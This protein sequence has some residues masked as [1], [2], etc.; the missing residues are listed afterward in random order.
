MN[1][2][3]R[4]TVRDVNDNAPYFTNFSTGAP[5]TQIDYNVIEN[6]H[7]MDTLGL[8]VNDDDTGISGYVFNVTS[9]PSIEDK[10][11]YSYG[12][13]L[14]LLVFQLN[15]TFDREET[16]NITISITVSN[17]DAPHLNSTAFV[18]IYVGDVNDNAPSFTHDLFTTYASEGSPTAKDVL[19]LAASDRDAGNN[20]RLTYNITSVDNP[21][22]KKWFNIS[23]STGAI[24]VVSNDIDY[25]AVGGEVVL[26]V[27]V[28]DNGEEEQLSTSTIVAVKI[29]PAI[30]FSARSHQAF[31]NYNL[32]GP[33]SYP[34]YLEFQTSADN[35][36]LLYQQNLEGDRF[37]L[38]LEER[39]VVLRV[40]AELPVV[41]RSSILDNSV[42]WYSVKVER[43]G[44]VSAIVKY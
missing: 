1:A 23:S 17:T 15:A 3:V 14:R 41:N 30:T 18:N 4:V 31:A 36:I 19:M 42:S 11:M 22:A 8:Q 37:Q 13:E 27:T 6:N 40:G 26:N 25:S 39:T 24:T 28:H 32:A 9:K 2:F 5:F 29:V 44:E 35:G 43:K 7:L 38:A 10:Y 12:V 33:E 16:P 20:S 21:T 34:V